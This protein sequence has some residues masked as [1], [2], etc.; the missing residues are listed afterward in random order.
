MNYKEFFDKHRDDVPVTITFHAG[1]QIQHHYIASIEYLYQAF[2]ARMMD[3]LHVNLGDA[4]L[5]ES[6]DGYSER[7]HG[8]LEEW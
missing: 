3:E 5:V 2:K 1:Q 4:G 6:S 7:V 8:K